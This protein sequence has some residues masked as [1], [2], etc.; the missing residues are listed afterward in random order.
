MTSVVHP[1]TVEYLFHPAIHDDLDAS[2]L[3]RYICLAVYVDKKKKIKKERSG[4]SKKII[5]CLYFLFFS[6]SLFLSFFLFVYEFFAPVDDKN[7]RVNLFLERLIFTALSVCVLFTIV[8]KVQI[9]E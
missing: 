3:E 8:D 5:F 4:E 2:C 9:K 7:R 1:S 6:L